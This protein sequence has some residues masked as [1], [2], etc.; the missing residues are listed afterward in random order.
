RTGVGERRVK[1]G[2]TAT[3][4]RLQIYLVGTDTETAH[5]YQLLG[6]FKYICSQLGAG[7][8]A[9]EVRISD[10]LDQLFL[11]K[12][13]AQVLDIGVARSIQGINGRL[14]N[15]FQQQDPDFALFERRI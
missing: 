13:M 10:L 6:S 5:S 3:G 15:A 1:H 8:D 12:R 4:G 11:A 9:D 7:A 14:M 2:D